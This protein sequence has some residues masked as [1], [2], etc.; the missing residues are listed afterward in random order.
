MTQHPH[1]GDRLRHAVN[2]AC[3]PAPG[4]FNAL[5]ARLVARAGFEAC[6]VSGAATSA[7]AAVPDIGILTLDHFTH[8]VA[9][10][11]AAA[12]DDLG[13]IPVIADADTGFGEAEMVRR[14]VIEYNHAGAAALHIEDQVSPKR[15]GHLDGK[16]LVPID[17][18][19]EKIQWAARASRDCSGG[20][21]IVC[22]RTDARSVEGMDAAIDRAK[23]YIQA[24][25]E[26][27]FPEGLETEHEFAAF[28]SSLRTAAPKCLL[29]ANMTEF[30]KTPIIPL[31]RFTQM[32][33]NLVIYP[34]T[35]L[36]VAMGAVSR[37]LEALKRDGSVAS[38]L[39]DMQTRD[40]L[41]DAIGYTPG[42]PW[43]IPGR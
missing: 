25:A 19:A 9:E 15:C 29:L 24:G 3:V 8:A 35:T 2:N 10:V 30:G 40:E 21:L 32:G 20:S 5:A 39:G 26:M 13:P 41:Y 6:Y 34:V 28:A 37:A 22:A 31:S 42:Q 18:A 12:R 33:Y 23:A 43:E 27:I 7:N 38:F 11:C 16:T 36:R 1:P 14:T 4:A 17:H